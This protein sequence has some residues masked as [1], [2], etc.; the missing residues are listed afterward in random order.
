MDANDRCEKKVPLATDGHGFLEAYI[1][2]YLSTGWR[3]GSEMSP[4]LKGKWRK[5]KAI[6]PI[7][8]LQIIGLPS[9]WIVPILLTSYKIYISPTFLPRFQ[10]A[11]PLLVLRPDPS[12]RQ[13]S[14][15]M[16]DADLQVVPGPP[17][18]RLKRRV[19]EEFLRN[20]FLDDD[21]E[22]LAHRLG[23]ERTAVAEAAQGLCQSHFLKMAGRGGFM[24]TMD[25]S[26]AK[27]A[28]LPKASFST[29][30]VATADE[31]FPALL[32]EEEQTLAEEIGCDF[33]T[34]EMG[35]LEE[36]SRRRDIA[37][38][39]ATAIELPGVFGELFADSDVAISDLVESLPFGVVVFQENGVLEIANSIAASWLGIS[40]RDLDGATFEMA[41]GVN[42]L[43][44]V[45]GETPV[46]F[47]LTAPHAVEIG[48]SR[49]ILTAGPAVLIVIR[50]VSLQEEV[51]RVQRLH[52]EEIFERMRE[53]MVDPL[54][55][56]EQFLEHPDPSGLIQ[57]RAAMEQINWLLPEFFLGK[58][59]EQGAEPGAATG[60][61][62]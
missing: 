18:A 62:A 47:S 24:L 5:I 58:R 44:V 13:G 37:I 17:H 53:E 36:P 30:D 6:G 32:S 16:Q 43:L 39:L 42:P 54:I 28:D 38:A 59:S 52:Q 56:I 31:E 23:E 51:T 19:L 14:K 35:G 46:S 20:P 12:G 50:D 7:G 40:M 26:A 48:M 33:D 15:D 9:T 49:C 34:V 21:A 45:D 4:V 25:L 57:A 3:A 60:G 41:T 29:V 10:L 27:L 11:A 55:M 1:T 2:S 61:G 22:R 8:V